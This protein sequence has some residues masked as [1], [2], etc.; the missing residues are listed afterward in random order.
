[1]SKGQIKLVGVYV[2]FT[3]QLGECIGK[4]AFGK[5]Y[6]ALNIETGQIVAIKQIS[7]S[8]ISED[9]ANLIQKEISLMKRL[10]HKNIVKYIGKFYS[11][12]ISNDKYLSIVLEYVENGSISGIIKKFSVFQEGLVAFFIS[13]VVLGLKYL[14]SQGV[15]HRDIKGANLLTTKEG[16]VKLADFGVAMRLTESTKSMSIVGTPYWMAP[17]IV[18][19]T[20][21]C[22]TSCDIWSLGC[23]VIE[24]LTGRPPYYD[25]EPM[26]ALYRIVQDDY[27][28]FP[29]NISPEL[30]DFLMK[31]FQKEPLIRQNAKDLLEHPWLVNIPNKTPEIPEE[32]NT[33]ESD[34]DENH[35][36]VHQSI[37]EVQ[38]SVDLSYSPQR[39]SIVALRDLLNNPRKSQKVSE[40]TKRQSTASLYKTENSV[41]TSELT[42]L[43]E[44]VE[45][46]Q[47]PRNLYRVLHLLTNE[48][49]LIPHAASLLPVLKLVLDTSEEVECLHFALQTTNLIC[50]DIDLQEIAACIG[51]LSSSLT[52]IGDEFCQE[53]RIESAFLIGQFFQS[54]KSSLKLM[55]ASGGT[56]AIIKLLDPNFSENKQFVILGIDC[57]LHLLE[58]GTH[59]LATW[60]GHG[61]IERLALALD[62]LS[63]ENTN[64]TCIEKAADLLLTFSTVKDI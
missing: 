34:E 51:L 41:N 36:F 53:L 11:D 5:V 9:Q 18:E 62:N 39:K 45:T 13:Q 27:P 17:E 28:P 47:S 40:E 23:T 10:S 49:N 48:S 54:S 21:H 32:I 2:I 64:L 50:N 35:S 38:S 46:L 15:V 56:E 37:D 1:M 8:N 44:N 58:E 16:T 6:K 25:L 57:L 4:G 3:Q 7:I 52:Y 55:L 59:Y 12:V 61:A 14:H 31:C 29:P 26:S 30:K 60:A 63:R 33:Q 42:Q 22:T 43:I 19:Q 24:L 20:G